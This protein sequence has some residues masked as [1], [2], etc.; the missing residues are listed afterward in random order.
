VIAVK[1]ACLGAVLSCLVLGAASP[2]AAQILNVYTN[3]N[4]ED[5]SCF[6]VHSNEL[7]DLYVIIKPVIPS[8]PPNGFSY[9]EFGSPS[10]AFEGSG[11]VP[12]EYINVFPP[13]D[14]FGGFKY[15]FGGCLVPPIHVLTIRAFCYQAPPPCRSLWVNP[16]ELRDCAGNP[17]TAY[18]GEGFSGVRIDTLC[19]LS[20][21]P[22]VYPPDGS[23]HVPLNAVLSWG[24]MVGP[25]R[26]YGPDH[27]GVRIGTTPN[28]PIVSNG[29]DTFYDPP[30]LL[31]DNTTYYWSISGLRTGAGEVTTATWTFS[32]GE[33]PVATRTS[34]WGKIKA[35][36]R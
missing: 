14:Q 4:G 32:T 35:L 31:Q 23:T 21:P 11:V 18:G 9:V 19:T 20:P 5:T 2:T 33:G 36:Y 29:F 7:F 12:V 27:F 28:T 22:N 24:E 3:L 15:N 8:D 25:S 16:L 34:T 6:E 17:V 1:A 30:G 26:C 10:D 13:A